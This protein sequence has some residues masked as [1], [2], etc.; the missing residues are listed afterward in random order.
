MFGLF[1][2][3][4]WSL[5]PQDDAL[6]CDDPVRATWP[7]TGVNPTSHSGITSV[8]NRVIG[9]EID[10]ILVFVQAAADV[11]YALSLCNESAKSGSRV[12]LVVV[13]V[14]SVF[15]FL[16]SLGLDFVSV[17]FIPYVLLRY[18]RLPWGPFAVRL[19]LAKIYRELFINRPPSSIYFFCSEFDAITPYF[20]RRLATTTSVF[21]AD[22]YG[23]SVRRGR[24]WPMSVLLR[25]LYL[26]VATGVSFDFAE[27][28]QTSTS[29]WI[30]VFRS[31]SLG[32]EAAQLR[33]SSWRLKTTDWLSDVRPPMVL[34]L[35]D[36]CENSPE[37]SNYGPTILDLVHTLRE[38]GIS[39][40]LKAHPR[41]GYSMCLAPLNLPTLPAGC[42]VELLDISKMSAVIALNSLGLSRTAKEGLLALSLLDI[43]AFRSA[44]VREWWRC[45]IDRHSNGRVL[46]PRSLGELVELVTKN[47]C[48]QAE[49]RTQ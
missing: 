17:D 10:E 30:S 24:R 39:V 49:L 5:L 23:M 26:R 33:P 41:S 32:V 37:T 22:H 43:V 4:R 46:Y 44:G 48:P 28:E 2:V 16:V 34:L 9:Q 21:V 13:N 11:T 8:Q 29:I 38:R 14:K 20:I 18:P 40:C 6:F 19:K 27:A 15:D 31:E 7:A 35:D 25:W 1:R 47:A 36:D 42:P 3:M 45:W 12:R